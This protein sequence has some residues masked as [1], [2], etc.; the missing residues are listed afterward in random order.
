MKLKERIS[1]ISIA[2]EASL[3]MALHQM[4]QTQKHL[5]FVFDA[6]LYVS[7]ISIGDIQRAIIKG[8]SLKTPVYKILRK[9]IRT[10]YEKDSYE[11]VKALMLRYRV[12]C[13]PIIN[14]KGELVDVYFWEEVFGKELKRNTPNINIP[15]V[16]MA[17]G[18]G[19]R[20]KPLTNILPKP[21]IPIGEK[22]IIEEIM[23][24]FTNVGC[25][26]FFISVNYKADTIKYYFET[27]NNKNYHIDYFQEDKP[28][29]TAGSMFLI[30]DKIKTTFF[31][32]NCDIIIDQDLEEIYNYH[33][34]NK[35]VITIV[36]ALKHYKI[37][38]GTVESG[39][40][41]VLKSLVEKPDLTFHI[42]SGMYILE[43][44][45]LEKI[46]ENKFMHITELIGLIKDLEQNVGVFPISEGSWKDIGEW[47]QYLKFTK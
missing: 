44:E 45:V 22:T 15:V 42:N 38:Y 3:L 30:K 12:E 39:I 36:S 26:N 17:G 11:E 7:L 5:L 47:D 32:S 23:N 8:V 29:G 37:P 16:I 14:K 33:K 24:K 41:G 43:P 18:K 31:V 6:D 10:A 40:N 13:M 9:S 4:D 21:L 25:S 46:P 19:T 1:N 28:L 35:N 34:E 20:L 2:K 27:L